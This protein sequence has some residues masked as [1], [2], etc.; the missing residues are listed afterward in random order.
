[1]PLDITDAELTLMQLL[2]KEYPL[3]ARELTERLEAEKGWHRKTVNTLLSRLAKKGAI[4]REKASTGAA[5]WSPLIDRR[6]HQVSVTSTFVDEHFD[7]EIAPLVASFA[8]ARN[9]D[10]KQ[11]AELQDML[12]RIFDDD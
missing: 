3:T 10:D 1:M 11:I 8:E 6:S 2:W 7:G 5:A 9:L 12:D 4:Q